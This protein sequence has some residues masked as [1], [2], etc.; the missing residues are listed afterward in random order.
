[1]K[2]MKKI[3]AVILAATLLMSLMGVVGFANETDGFLE[4]VSLYRNTKGEYFFYADGYLDIY[5]DSQVNLYEVSEDGDKLIK[6]FSEEESAW[7]SN[8]YPV[9]TPELSPEKEYYFEV[10]ECFMNEAGEIYYE[11]NC[12]SFTYDSMDAEKP[13]FA[14]YEL[15]VNEN[16]TIDIGE[17]VLFPIGYESG[18]SFDVMT[19]SEFYDEQYLMFEPEYMSVEGNKITVLNDGE[20]FV[21]LLDCDGKPLDYCRIEILEAEPDSFGEKIYDAYEDFVGLASSFIGNLGFTGLFGAFW[22]II[23]LAAPFAILFSLI[24]GI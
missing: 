10:I 17:Y 12:Y 3:I 20:I 23:I 15:F 11:T 5:F 16:E 2:T 1:M 19:E 14:M 8:G 7:F 22:I 4:D 6:E 13:V 9:E 21:W 24:F 18:V